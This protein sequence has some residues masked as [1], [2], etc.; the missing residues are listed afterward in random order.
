MSKEYMI[1]YTV[2][3]QGYTKDEPWID[4]TTEDVKELVELYKDFVVY[5]VQYQPVHEIWIE[6]REIGPWQRVDPAT[7]G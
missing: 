7:L 1:C 2:N 5:M 6:C 4:T 3:G